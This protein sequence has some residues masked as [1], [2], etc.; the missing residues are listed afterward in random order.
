MTDFSLL[1][2][3]LIKYLR[4]LGESFSRSDVSVGNDTLRLSL[5]EGIKVVL[6]QSRRSTRSIRHGRKKD[7]IFGIAG[8][9]GSGVS[10][11]ESVVPDGE[12]SSDFVVFRSLVTAR[13]AEKGSQVRSSGV[14]LLGLNLSQHRKRFG[15]TSGEHC[16]KDE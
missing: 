6:D 12:K 14:K 11:S 8:S 15:S 1:H 7:G 9:N 2:E 3:L 4:V 13:E 5:Q 10:C 16:D